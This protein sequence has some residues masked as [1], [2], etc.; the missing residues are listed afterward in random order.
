MNY[1]VIRIGPGVSVAE[2][3]RTVAPRLLAGQLVIHPTS[4][5]YGLGA[6]PRR[7]LN[8]EIDR[9]KGRS[10]GTPL[11]HLAASEIALRRARPELEWG[12]A[13]KR[14]A[15]AFWP[16]ALTLVMDDGSALGLAVRVDEHPAILALLE[17]A[18][19]LM[20]TT[21]LNRSGDR[22]ARCSDEVEAIAG[23]LPESPLEVTFLD[24][25]DLPASGPSTIVSLRSGR[26]RIVR[27][28]ALPV[29]PIETVLLE[30]GLG[31]T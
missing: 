22:P 1:Q 8:A 24:G 11:I 31:E 28:G 13:A 14:L 5:V 9:L 30:E 20:T 6:L 23:S 19:G 4:T 7:E 10:P 27:E 21:S 26:A 3:A 25:G 15:R 2:A 12:D 18:G 16:G 17:A 29:E